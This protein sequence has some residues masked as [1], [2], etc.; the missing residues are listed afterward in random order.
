LLITGTTSYNI[1]SLAITMNNGTG[2]NAA[3]SASGGATQTINS[4]IVT[5]SAS[6]LDITTAGSGTKLVLA[7]NIDNGV[8]KAVSLTANTGSVI[9]VNGGT[10]NSPGSMT[11]AGD[12]TGTVLMTGT[13]NGTGNMVVSAGTLGGGGTIVGAVDASSGTQKI[14]PSATAISPTTYNT[15]TVGSLSTSA[16]TTLSFNLVTADKRTPL[17]VLIPGTYDQIVVSS[18]LNVGG[19]TTIK[20][21]NVGTGVASLGYYR[22]LGY[23]SETGMNSLTLSVATQPNIF[24][25][26]DRTHDAG[27]GFIDIHRGFLGDANDDGTVDIFDFNALS[28][29]WQTATTNWAFGDFNGDGTVD[30]FDFN[31]LSQHWQTNIGV[32]SPTDG[33]SDFNYAGMLAALGGGS[34]VPEP[35]SLALLGLGVVGL[36]ARRRRR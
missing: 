21:E 30:I 2:G 28:Q 32:G 3:I 9:S 26:L 5:S 7:G 18:A 13:M 14:Y 35:T 34:S 11:V 33:G 1:G 16:T 31:A 29:H 25:S 6:D 20:I 19:A 22:V 8:G 27:T 12:G 15:L 23:G 36:I 4:Q 17:N 10:N 24:Y